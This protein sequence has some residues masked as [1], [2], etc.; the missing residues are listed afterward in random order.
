MLGTLIK[1]IWGTRQRILENDLSEIDYLVL[2]KDSACSIHNHDHKINR[3]ILLTGKVY[4]KSDLG[5]YE[6]KH[7][8]PFDVHPPLYH[9]FIVDEDSTMIEVA[10]VTEGKID[11]DDINRVK[12]GGKFIEEVID[13]DFG[14]TTKTFYTLDQ[15]KLNEWEDDL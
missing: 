5:T 15:L 8:I 1:K 7:N 6:L 9:Q 2:D 12:Q 11:P 10:Y 13:A 3:F 14:F 4:I